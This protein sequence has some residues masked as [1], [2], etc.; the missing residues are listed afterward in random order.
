MRCGQSARGLI[1]YHHAHISE[2]NVSLCSL[3]SKA[4]KYLKKHFKGSLNDRVYDT[5]KELFGNIN[6][7]S[8]KEALPKVSV[9]NSIIAKYV[10][11]INLKYDIELSFTQL[12]ATEVSHWAEA[13]QVATSSK[14][15]PRPQQLP[16]PQ[17]TLQTQQCNQP[18]QPE[19]PQQTQQQ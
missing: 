4:H 6:T 13:F 14:D 18:L 15:Q 16:Q 11:E 9:Y 3:D 8:I 1:Y 17:H 19:Q 2:V 12:E 7:D 10:E 5:F